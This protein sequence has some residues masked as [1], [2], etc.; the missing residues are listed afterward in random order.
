[1]SPGLDNLAR[2]RQA[3]KHVL[4]EA[5]VAQPA[6]ESCRLDHVQRPQDGQHR[7]QRGGPRF[8]DYNGL[9]V[10]NDLIY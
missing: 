3:H 1:M 2:F 9:D 6:V 4:V 5:F 8:D 10:H 7:H